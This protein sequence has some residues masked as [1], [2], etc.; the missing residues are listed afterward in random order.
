MQGIE[1]HQ[2]WSLL[3]VYFGEIFPVDNNDVTGFQNDSVGRKNWMLI[4]SEDAAH[5]AGGPLFPV[6]G[7]LLTLQG[8]ARGSCLSA[9]LSNPPPEIVDAGFWFG[10]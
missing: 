8:G 4:G 6:S 1:F 9:T 3:P 5:A 2:N 7:E 10:R